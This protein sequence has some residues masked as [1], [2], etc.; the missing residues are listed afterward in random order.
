MGTPE[1]PQPKSQ[2]EHWL[3]MI[4]YGHLKGQPTLFKIDGRPVLAEDVHQLCGE[5]AIPMFLALERSKQELG[6]DHPEYQEDLAAA[7]ELI[8]MH[9]KVPEE[10]S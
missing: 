4:G 10:S 3:D 1:A 5:H 9:F 7:R 6:P 8:D 2:G